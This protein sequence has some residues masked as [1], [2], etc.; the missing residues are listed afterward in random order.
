MAPIFVFLLS[1]PKLHGSL[2]CSCKNTEFF[3][4]PWFPKR[5]LQENMLSE[6]EAPTLRTS[7]TGHGA[8]HSVFT[9][10][11][12]HRS[13]HFSPPDQKTFQNGSST[14]LGQNSWE[15]TQIAR[16]A[17]LKHG[18]SQ[19]GQPLH[20]RL[21]PEL[22]RNSDYKPNANHPELRKRPFPLTKLPGPYV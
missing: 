14:T 16:F 4:F 13:F 17:V 21:S 9:H 1:N 6:R 22:H 18:S 7:E 3:E 19:L 10:P 8:A 20:H 11:Q 12:K 2:T 5:G 15:N